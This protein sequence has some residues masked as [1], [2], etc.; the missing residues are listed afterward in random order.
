MPLTG[1]FAADERQASGRKDQ[2][3]SAVPLIN[4]STNQLL[5][6]AKSSGFKS[7]KGRIQAML[8]ELAA[9]GIA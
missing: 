6:G 4:P 8:K 9:F 5:T 3:T 1:S 7:V 2:L